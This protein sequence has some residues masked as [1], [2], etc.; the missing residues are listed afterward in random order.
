MQLSQAKERLDAALARKDMILLVADCAVKYQGR[1]ASNLPMG[2]RLL[3]IKGDGSFAIHQNRLLRPTNYL[4]STG[5]STRLDENKLVVE[6]T[7]RSPKESLMVFIERVEMLNIHAMEDH[8]DDFK[9]VG[10]EKELNDQLMTDLD[11]LEK[12]LKPL[13]QESALRKGLIDIMAEDK[14]GNLVVIELKRR[15]ADYNSVMQLVRYVNEVK[16]IKNR[17]T[18]GL[19]VAPTIGR[20]ALELLKNNGLEY[21]SYTFDVTQPKATIEGI[22]SKQRTIFQA[23]EDNAKKKNRPTGDSKNPQK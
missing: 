16:K 19:L 11:V 3:L 13:K 4:M 17:K 12:G 5:W 23:L 15:Q 1:A 20:P 21:F 14:D 18:R 22:D 10:T 7:K 6:A 9:L 2:N 8:A